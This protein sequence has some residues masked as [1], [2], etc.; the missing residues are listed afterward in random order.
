MLEKDNS[1]VFDIYLKMRW[2]IWDNRCF[3][4]FNDVL[5]KLDK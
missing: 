2:N 1:P 3:V 5:E 4:L